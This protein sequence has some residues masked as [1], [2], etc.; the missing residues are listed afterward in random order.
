MHNFFITVSI[1]NAGRV[2][3]NT[4][5]I[6]SAMFPVPTAS[7]ARTSRRVIIVD[8]S[9]EHT[10]VEATTRT[11]EQYSVPYRRLTKRE[12]EKKCSHSSR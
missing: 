11:A 9:C 7:C 2:T 1:N 3:N 4:K 10:A 6:K 12:S 5:G 8:I